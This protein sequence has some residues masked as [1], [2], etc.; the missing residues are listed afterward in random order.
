MANN[1]KN[2]NEVKNSVIKEVKERI[3]NDLNR[4]IKLAIVNNTSKFKE[5]LHDEISND[6]QNEVANI[7]QHEEKRIVQN[8]NFSVFK[9][10]I[11][12]VILVIICFYFGYCLF[13]ARYFN[14]MKSECEKN[15][16]CNVVETT[17]SSDTDSTSENT[18]EKDNE[19]Y[20]ENYGYLLD[21]VKVNLNADAV[22]AYYLYSGD[23][24]I[25]EIKS[26]Y[27][28]NMAYSKLDK[29]SIKTNTQTIT[30]ESED[31]K[32][33][34]ESLFGSSNYYKATNFT[35]NCL[36][37]TYNSEK[38]RFTATNTKCT[39]S[40]K[41]I[42]ESIDNIFLEGDVLYLTTYATIYDSSEATYYTFDDLFNP[43][44]NNVTDSD[45]TSQA[46][47]LNRYQYQ[48]KKVDGKY[49]LDSITKLK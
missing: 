16:T 13:D 15:G 6:I 47:R 36:N 8:R 18:E 31:L 7:M 29:K 21:D 23:Y 24:N 32:K 48:F 44:A 1:E 4:E 28:L 49:Y 25:S 33:A 45:L 5:E 40:N 35:Y 22:N 46:K 41:Q 20:I 19:W 27:L 38:E 43:V 9:R 14:F 37:F 17:T 26:A 12:I 10:D 42:L 39:T 3:L 2:D 11:A 34:F 30:V